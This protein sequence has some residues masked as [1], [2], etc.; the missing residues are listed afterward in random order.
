MRLGPAQGRRPK[1]WS[2]RC[3]TGH[4]RT[5]QD[6]PSHFAFNLQGRRAMP[7]KPG[8]TSLAWVRTPIYSQVGCQDQRICQRAVPPLDREAMD[9]TDRMPSK[10][11]RDMLAAPH[12]GGTGV[13]AYQKPPRHPAPARPQEARKHGAL[14]RYRPGR[15]SSDL[16]TDR[17]S[18]DCHAAPGPGAFKQD[19]CLRLPVP[20]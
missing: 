3:V 2:P 6:P 5:G 11:L 15:R 12:E 10:G 9:Q 1:A 20:R 8:L 4:D 18:S 17:S 7:L 14:P 19:C 13:P 16:K